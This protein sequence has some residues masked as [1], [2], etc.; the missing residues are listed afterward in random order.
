MELLLEADPS[1]K[2]VN[3][4][5]AEGRCYIAETEGKLVGVYVLLALSE[6]AAEIKNIAVDRAE[7]G[8]GYGKKIIAHALEQA[9]DAGFQHVE[10]GT[11]NSSFDQL[12]LYQKCGFRMKSIEPDFFTHHYSEPIIENG[13]LCQD[14]VRLQYSF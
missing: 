8:K 14:M 3:S 5:L 13:L 10:I 11:G 6:T 4:Y 2:L 12:A 7:R 9:E 1:V